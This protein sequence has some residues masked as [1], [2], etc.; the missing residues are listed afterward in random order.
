MG[1][2]KDDS[3]FDASTFV[4]PTTAHALEQTYIDRHHFPGGTG[5]AAEDANALAD[6]LAGRKVDLVGTSNAVDGPDR[7]ADGVLIQ[8]KYFAKSRE[9]VGAAFNADGSYRYPGMQLEV[10]SDQYDACVAVMRERIAEGKIPGH[11]NP[12]DA[13]Q[14]IKKGS[15][16]YEQ[17]RNIAKAGNIDSLTYDVKSGAIGA[18]CAFGISF[19]VTFAVMK[20]NGASTTEALKESALQG[21]ASGSLSL[22]ASVVSA[23]MLRT[24]GAAI[25]KVA[26][27]TVVKK[28]YGTDS[29]KAVIERIAE[30]SLGKA[31]SGSAAYNH[32]AKLL[33]SNVVTSVCVTVVVSTPDFYRAA[34]SRSISWSQ[35]GKNAAVNASG[36]AAG[37]GG[38][39]AGAAGGAALGSVVPV[40]GT[41]AGGII[42]GIVG[43]LALGTAGSVGAKAALDALIDDDEKTMLGMLV[44]RASIKASAY[45]LSDAEF[46][47]L[48][49]V[50]KG[51]IGNGL[52]RAMFQSGAASEHADA[53]LEEACTLITLARPTIIVPKDDVILEAANSVLAEGGI[54]G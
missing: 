23:Q 38:W 28:V 8:T 15:V 4:A 14:I 7:I 9:T 20:W 3:R 41:A 35:F 19:V 42:G 40:I 46:A 44:E 16:T 36:V 51:D 24:K 21:L 52:L 50:M 49:E 10:P 47:S 26:A 45:L 48:V 27:R 2:D 25:G 31:V 43:S 12:D 18:S 22:T 13:S 29:G 5:F 11:H 53:M 34:F 30:A 37:S 33:R 32:V 39:V 1:K 6:R 54:D 17:A